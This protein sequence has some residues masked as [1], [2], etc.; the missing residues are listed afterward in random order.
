MANVLEKSCVFIQ[1]SI[2]LSPVTIRFQLLRNVVMF[3]PLRIEPRLKGMEL[4]R[5]GGEV[6]P[7][8]AIPGGSTRKGTYECC[9]A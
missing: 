4:G 5:G 9:A 3:F 1:R 8:I 6:V 2:G 7:T